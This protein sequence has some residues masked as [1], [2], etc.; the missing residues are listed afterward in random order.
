MRKWGRENEIPFPANPNSAH[1][2]LSAGGSTWF[3]QIA[4]PHLYRLHEAGEAD[5]VSPFCLSP[6]ST[7][8]GDPRWSA[9]ATASSVTG[10]ASASRNQSG[11]MAMK[12]FS[13][14][15]WIIVLLLAI[16]L[17]GLV[18]ASGS[19][20]RSAEKTAACITSHGMF[21]GP[22]S[23]DARMLFHFAMPPYP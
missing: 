3:D 15:R 6:R 1:Q 23:V 7:G 18:C 2:S 8:N 10:F 9:S 5:G 22:R 11:A 16:M 21:V 19:T 12:T 13:W 20:G 14:R 17:L 4:G